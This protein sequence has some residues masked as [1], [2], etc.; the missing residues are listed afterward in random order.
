MMNE[1]FHLSPNDADYPVALRHYRYS[2]T[3]PTISAIGYLSILK[4]SN[5][6]AFASSNAT[7][8]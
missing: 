3:L 8:I 4:K 6:R 7:T 5:D 2:K 1:L